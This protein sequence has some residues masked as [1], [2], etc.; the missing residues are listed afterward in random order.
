MYKYI[1]IKAVMNYLPDGLMEEWSEADIVKT[2]MQGYK[3][4]VQNSFI[5]YNLLFCVSKIVDHVANLPL[6][7]KGILDI[8]YSRYKMN[9]VEEGESTNDPSVYLRTDYNGRTTSIFQAMVFNDV[10]KYTQAMR[11]TGQNSELVHNGCLNLLCNDCLNWSIDKSLETVTA[12][13]KDGYLYILYKAVPMDGEE[14][15]LP[16]DPNLLQALAYY[17]EAKHWQSRSFRKEENANNMFV[18][19]MQMANAAFNEFSAKHMLREFDPD[20]FV[21]QTQTVNKIPALVYQRT[22][23][24]YR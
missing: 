11:Y 6:G 16:D 3:S 12:D 14:F 8:S 20:N 1:S 19:R 22:K 5:R 2:A 18:E 13:A 17:V 21:F 15:L 9:P 23:N 4:N 24:I 10:R 7:L